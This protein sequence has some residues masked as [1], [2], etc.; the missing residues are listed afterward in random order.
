MREEIS[1][2]SFPFCLLILTFCNQLT[3]GGAVRSLFWGKGNLSSEELALLYTLQ[4]D[5]LTLTLNLTLSTPPDPTR[6][7]EL[8]E[9]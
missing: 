5:L 3:K 4:Y 6:N 2:A 1:S 9:I 8:I 7:I